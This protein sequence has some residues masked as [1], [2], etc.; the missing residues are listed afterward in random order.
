MLYSTFSVSFKSWKYNSLT[1][2]QLPVIAPHLHL[3]GKLTCQMIDKWYEINNLNG[4]STVKFLIYYTVFLPVS[5]VSN[6]I[7][8]ANGRFYSRS[9]LICSLRAYCKTH[10]WPLLSPFAWRATIWVRVKL[11]LCFMNER[12]WQADEPRKWETP[13]L[14]LVFSPCGLIFPVIQISENAWDR[15]LQLRTSN[16]NRPGGKSFP[17]AAWWCRQCVEKCLSA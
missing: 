5:A 7:Y 13:S 16:K 6:F 4:R 12:H 11:R 3:D 10:W 1:Y 9:F 17:S 15:T 14:A 8:Y 2:S